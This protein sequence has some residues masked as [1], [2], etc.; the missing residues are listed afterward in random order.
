VCVTCH[1]PHGGGDIR[2]SVN[3]PVTP[4]GLKN[5]LRLSPAD[6]VST[7]CKECHR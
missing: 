1:N 6:N 5:M 3:V 2:D 4:I 7:L